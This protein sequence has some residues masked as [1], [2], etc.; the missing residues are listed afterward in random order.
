MYFLS[1]GGWWIEIRIPAGLVPPEASFLS[2]EDGYLL[3]VSFFRGC[4]PLVSLCVTTFPLLT[5]TSV[6]LDKGLPQWLHFNLVIS[7]KRCNQKHNTVSKIF[8]PQNGHF[9]KKKLLFNWRIIDL[10]NFVFCQISTWISHRYT[11]VS[12]LLN[13]PLFSLPLSPL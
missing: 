10:Q 6:R 2:P 13:H 5:K 3:A 4:I 11:Y 9:F 12:S 1:S 7:L 8:S